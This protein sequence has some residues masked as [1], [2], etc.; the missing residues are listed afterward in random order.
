LSLVVLARDR[1]GDGFFA[2]PFRAARPL[3]A[4]RWADRR[5]RFEV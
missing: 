2:T 3:A 1:F 5:V 4:S